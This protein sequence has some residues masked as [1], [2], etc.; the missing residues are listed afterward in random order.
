MSA[1]TKPV[2]KATLPNFDKHERTN[3]ACLI[4]RKNWLDVQIK[5]RPDKECGFFRLERRALRW[6]IDE[7]SKLGGQTQEVQHD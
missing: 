3:M 4:E 5:E 1:H 6:A 7:L 2:T